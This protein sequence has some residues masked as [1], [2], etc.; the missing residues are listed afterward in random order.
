[1]EKAPQPQGAIPS[2]M[3]YAASDKGPPSAADD[4]A[5]MKRCQSF[6]KVWMSHSRNTKLFLGI[7][8]EMESVSLPVSPAGSIE[9]L[10]KAG[11]YGDKP[12]GDISAAS[13]GQGHY[14]GLSTAFG[15]Q[16]PSTAPPA[17][18]QAPG[19][20]S[21]LLSRVSSESAMWKWLTTSTPAASGGPSFQG[22][23]NGPPA[24]TGGAAPIL[25]TVD[26]PQ[27]KGLSVRRNLSARDLNA[28]S[29]THW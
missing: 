16:K 9:N 27:N 5:P 13:R 29:P 18:S 8:E 21:K 12:A 3:T 20:P 4:V 23:M 15:Q 25:S 22:H 1:M 24:P 10:T 17:T 14:T 26:G 2:G 19:S 7:Q 6:D 28:I 11:L